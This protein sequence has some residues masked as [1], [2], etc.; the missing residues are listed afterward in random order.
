VNV[1]G[2]NRMTYQK[3]IGALTAKRDAEIVSMRKKGATMQEIANAVGV[4]RQRVQQI[5]AARQS[6]IN[7][8][9][10]CPKRG[11]DRGGVK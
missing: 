2:S 5:L 1:A 8:E 9:A 4:T 3:E 7:Y 11:R 10:W 6:E